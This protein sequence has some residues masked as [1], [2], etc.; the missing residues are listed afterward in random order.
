MGYRTGKKCTCD[1]PD[2]CDPYVGPAECPHHVLYECPDCGG[3]TG[4]G[5]PEWVLEAREGLVTRRIVTG[6]F[7][8]VE[9]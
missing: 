8:R 4:P 5:H 2:P 1:S 6:K 7:R 9:K 3:E